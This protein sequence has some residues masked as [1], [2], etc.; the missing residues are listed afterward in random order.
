MELLVSSLLLYLNIIY[1]IFQMKIVI[2]IFIQ[3]KLL[4]TFL[5]KYSLNIYF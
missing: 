3:F 2:S 1:Q 5:F 4:I